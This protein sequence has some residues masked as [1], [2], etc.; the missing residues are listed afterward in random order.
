[1]R[2]GGLETGLDERGNKDI[3]DLTAAR[4]KGRGAMKDPG[5][6]GKFARYHGTDLYR[7]RCGSSP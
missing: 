4:H 7:P 3:D 2:W 5:N 1:M 6:L